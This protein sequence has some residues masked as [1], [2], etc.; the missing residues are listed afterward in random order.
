M[1]S[2]VLSTRRSE[3]S[4]LIVVETDEFQLSQMCSRVDISLISLSL[5]FKLST[6]VRFASGLRSLI[7]LSSKLRTTSAVR[8]ATADISLIWMLPKFINV[9]AV[10]FATADI[11]L[12]WL[13]PKRQERERRP[14]RHRRYIAD[15]TANQQFP[16]VGK[17]CDRREVGKATNHYENFKISAIG[18][19]RD[20]SQVFVFVYQI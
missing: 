19:K 11:S 13:P 4:D 9:S 5:K 7:W 17:I 6:A 18:D 3:I 2:P 1:P 8:F 16:H 10:R 15:L 14:I 12:I 20:V